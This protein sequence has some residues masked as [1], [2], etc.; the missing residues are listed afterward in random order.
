M[1][2]ENPPIDGS[3]P[4]T[5]LPVELRSQFLSFLPLKQH[6]ELR[7]LNKSWQSVWNHEMR[8]QMNPLGSEK[9]V[10]KPI[11]TEKGFDAL[12]ESQ[13]EEIESL[14]ENEVE[15]LEKTKNAQTVI[16]EF[17]KLKGEITQ[18]PKDVISLHAKDK[19]LNNINEAIISVRLEQC[20]SKDS[21]E[22]DCTNCC[23]TRFPAS[24]IEKDVAVWQNLIW[25]SFAE[26]AL[27]ALPENIGQCV[28]LTTLELDDNALISLP[29]SISLCVALS[30]LN[31][32]FN[33]LSTL[34]EG[35]S[36]CVAL[37]EL[38]ISTNQLVSIPESIG[39]CKNLSKLFMD[40]NPL[41]RLPESLSECVALTEFHIDNNKLIS[42]PNNIGA[43]IALKVLAVANNNLV[44]LP[45][46]LAQCVALEKLSVNN[47]YL[48][49]I[50]DALSEII[51]CNSDFKETTKSFVL[52]AQ[53]KTAPSE[54]D[55]QQDESH[56][57]R[58]LKLG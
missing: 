21:K 43:C 31:V 20:N 51:F 30:E 5:E 17:A 14:L 3:S 47:N 57:T 18:K 23:L 29:E 9:G 50:S 35:L 15:I 2:A 26:N 53:R 34:P 44:E 56:Q 48:T 38:S 16:N 7:R 13:N 55:T 33:Y 37:E 40:D 25:L 8:R 49:T 54:E 52:S 6:L 19:I 4:I 46:S 1:K 39:Q 36:K 32:N 12:W 27:S 22:L 41:S 58:K 45:E 24:V 28:A 10:E 42:L 11:T